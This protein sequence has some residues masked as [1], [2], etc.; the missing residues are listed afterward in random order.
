MTIRRY[1]PF[2][3][4]ALLAVTAPSF[5]ATDGDIIR[6]GVDVDGTLV[7][8]PEGE[9]RLVSQTVS[10]SGA[11]N[12]LTMLR[13]SG[14][15]VTAAALIQ[16]AGAGSSTAWGKAPACE[17]HDLPLARVRYASDH[18]GS[19]AWT[20]LVRTVVTKHA[21][22]ADGA[23]DPSWL[24][25]VATA[26]RNRWRM[27]PAWSLVGLR[28]SDPRG[29]VQIRYAFPIQDGPAQPPDRA[30]VDAAWDRVELGFRRRIDRSTPLPDWRGPHPA[31]AATTPPP[32][33]TDA[34]SLLGRAVWKTVTFRAIVTTL[35]FSSNY[36]ALGNAASAAA[37][38]AF[39]FV[40][41][42]FVYLGHEMA[43]SYFSEAPPVELPGLGIEV[44]G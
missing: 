12:S 19:C 6:N 18:D 4:A 9:W 37:L 40:I 22:A 15:T 2:L 27:P 23:F 36:M 7:P 14:D 39:G 3:A 11:L 5:A 41:G 20:A 32:A 35:D 10:R 30:W 29:A 34:D 8:L 26:E 16:T 38:S 21:P 24:A 25:A 42:P 13:L 1:A 17:R 33:D 28:V 44:A 31:S 43:W